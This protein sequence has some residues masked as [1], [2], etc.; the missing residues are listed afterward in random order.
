MSVGTAEIERHW[1]A[2]HR[3]RR[4][5][6]LG[7]TALVVVALGASLVFANETSAGKFLERLPHLVD[8]VDQLIPREFA[9]I[10][11]ALFDLPSPFDDGSLK[12]DYPDGRVPLIDGLY[13]PEY[14]H[15]ML[16][17]INVAIL[18]TLIG[19]LIG[20]AASFLAAKNLNRSRLSRGVVRRVLEL[21]RAFPEIVIAGFFVAVLSLGPIP[22][23]IAIALHTIGALG[24]LF[25]EVIEN[26]DMRPVDGIVASG[27]GAVDTARYAILPQVAP[28][29]ASYTLLRFEINVRASTIIGA[30]GGG[31]IGEALRLSIS[32][33]HEAKTLAI[34]ALLFVIIVL[35]DQLGAA[36]RRRLAPDGGFGTSVRGSRAGSGGNVATAP[37]T[38]GT[39][40]WER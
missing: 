9:E 16:V 20:G 12:H 19:T 28:N 37:V 15:L 8:F 40:R 22:A 24:K 30:V 34:I 7:G 10:G 2:L 21:L 26:A 6:T 27:G 18:S 11:R 38:L 13:L 35:I 33:G 32:R 29:F 1:T 14:F 36:L 5:Y 39:T 31:G 17:T 4:L 23:I 3:Q 25:F